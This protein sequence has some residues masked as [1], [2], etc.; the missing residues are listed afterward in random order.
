MPGFASPQY[1]YILLDQCNVIDSAG[2]NLIR[3]E[4]SLVKTTETNSTNIMHTYCYYN[5]N[6]FYDK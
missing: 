2:F 4:T 6:K 5:T 1:R 3:I